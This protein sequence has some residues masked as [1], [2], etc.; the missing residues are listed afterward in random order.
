MDVVK[1]LIFTNH[2]KDRLQER[3]I[4]HADIHH[5]LN[6]AGISLPHK[7]KKKRIMAEIPGKSYLTVIYKETKTKYIIISVYWKGE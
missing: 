4:T 1:K 2:G 6:S 5:A 3:N 7:G